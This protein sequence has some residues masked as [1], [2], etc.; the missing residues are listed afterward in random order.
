M[1][2]D[3]ALQQFNTIQSLSFTS[4]IQAVY[5]L[6]NQF[7]VIISGVGIKAQLVQEIFLG[8]NNG[9]WFNLGFISI[10]T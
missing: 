10:C 1:N 6:G 7:T 3:N 5:K 2:Q 9:N 8:H 4:G